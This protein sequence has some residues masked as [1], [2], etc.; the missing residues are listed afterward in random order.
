MSHLR[1]LRSHVF[2]DMT[3][4]QLG[5]HDMAI[6]VLTDAR[7]GIIGTRSQRAGH[8]PVRLTCVSQHGLS[9]CLR[10]HK[11]G[12]RFPTHSQKFA[13]FMRFGYKVNVMVS[14][15]ST[16]ARWCDGSHFTKGLHG[17]G[18]HSVFTP[19]YQDSCEWRLTKIYRLR[20]TRIA[21]H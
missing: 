8:H 17:G 5:R 10:H 18:S 15:N 16:S 4:A 12:N 1:I 9:S 2:H 21:L 6:R 20:C 11:H 3:L 19:R 14:K 7:H 13:H